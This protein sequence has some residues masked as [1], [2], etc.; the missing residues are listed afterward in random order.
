MFTPRRVV[1]WMAVGVV[2]DDRFE[3]DEL[4]ARVRAGDAEAIRAVWNR[5]HTRLLRFAA[6]YVGSTDSAADLVQ[7]VFLTL[8]VQRETLAPRMSLESHL[9]GAV[10]FQALRELKHERVVRRYVRATSAR[11]AAEPAVAWHAGELA[12]EADETRAVVRQ[13]VESLTPRVREIFLM[14]REDG[15]APAEIASVLGIST[16]VVYNQ[17]AKAVKALSTGLEAQLRGE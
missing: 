2:T 11:Y 12:V 4:V 10:R 6:R 7:R 3:N 1:S 16:Q 9:F 17:I 14:H 13:I 5:Y 15:L 8:W